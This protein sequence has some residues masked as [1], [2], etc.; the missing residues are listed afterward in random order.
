MALTSLLILGLDKRD[1]EAQPL[2]SGADRNLPP[3]NYSKTFKLN[4]HIM[5]FE[6]FNQSVLLVLQRR[7]PVATVQTNMEMRFQTPLRAAQMT[8]PT[9]RTKVYSRTTHAIRFPEGALATFRPQ[10]VR[11]FADSEDEY[12]DD[13]LHVSRRL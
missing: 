12:Y 8:E 1:V 5:I 6:S 9:T 11:T 3:Q 10:L 4:P 13:A 7:H 2:P